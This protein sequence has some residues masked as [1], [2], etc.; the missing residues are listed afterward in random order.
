MKPGLLY[1]VRFVSTVVAGK[2]AGADDIPVKALKSVAGYIAP[3]IAY[4]I[5]ESFRHGEFPLKWKI[6]CVSL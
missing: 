3:T 1:L 4:L 5:N 6:A 2:E